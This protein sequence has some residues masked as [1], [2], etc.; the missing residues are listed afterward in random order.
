[1]NLTYRTISTIFHILVFAV[2]DIS[3]STTILKTIYP[4]PPVTAR[5]SKDFD[6]IEALGETCNHELD[7]I[8]ASLFPLVPKP[9]GHYTSCAIT[10]SLEIVKGYILSTILNSI[11]VIQEVLSGMVKGNADFCEGVEREIRRDEGQG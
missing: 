9:R 8:R 2:D 4:P 10:S 5:L 3:L 11:R 1:L 6:R 7:Q